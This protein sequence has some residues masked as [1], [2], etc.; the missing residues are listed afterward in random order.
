MRYARC[1]GLS[2][3]EIIYEGET[4]SLPCAAFTAET[5]STPD[6]PEPS[7]PPASPPQPSPHTHQWKRSME[8][9]PPH[10]SLV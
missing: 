5:S 2:V 3:P 10:N 6:C 4:E 1:T 8:E 7:T 9:E